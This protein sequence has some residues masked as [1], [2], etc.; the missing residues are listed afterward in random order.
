MG[1]INREERR[2]AG[3]AEIVQRLEN[4]LQEK[5]TAYQTLGTE[6]EWLQTVIAVGRERLNGHV[7]PP[8]RTMPENTLPEG[9][10]A[11]HCFEVLR[12]YE[13]PRSYRAVFN[14]VITV[15]R[16]TTNSVYNAM[17]EDPMHFTREGN[18]YFSVR[19]S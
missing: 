16:C 5:M 4:D 11:W 19:E 9:K 7:V 17:Y 15:H 14:E 6:I 12:K 8:A 2:M 3:L 10:L 1:I 13:G 18:G